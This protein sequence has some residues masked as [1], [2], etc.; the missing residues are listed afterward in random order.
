M[1]AKV[2]PRFVTAITNQG[3]YKH[4]FLNSIKYNKFL[5][6]I[7]NQNIHHDKKNIK[8]IIR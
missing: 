1:L 3:F 8:V 5:Q 4:S 2:Y 6:L 7:E